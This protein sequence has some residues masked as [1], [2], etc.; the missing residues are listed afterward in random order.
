MGEW[1]ETGPEVV[2]TSCGAVSWLVQVTV[3][4]TGTDRLA[5]EKAYPFIVTL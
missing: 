1:I 2:F 3:D 5:G 4:P